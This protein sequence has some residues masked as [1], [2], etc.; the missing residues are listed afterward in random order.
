MSQR[1]V[2]FNL[3]GRTAHI[4]PKSRVALAAGSVQS[5][6]QPA[7]TET[8]DALAIPGAE[9]QRRECHPFFIAFDSVKLLSLD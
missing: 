4:G 6:S 1:S 2:Q 9:T 7:S 5:Q 3:L 8:G